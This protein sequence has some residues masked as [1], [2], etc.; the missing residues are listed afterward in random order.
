MSESR[1]AEHDRLNR[2]TQELEREHQTLRGHPEDREGHVK[3]HEHLRQHIA[4]LQAF[5]HRL[6]TGRDTAL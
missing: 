5:I 6:R 4:D 3:H 1:D 2:R